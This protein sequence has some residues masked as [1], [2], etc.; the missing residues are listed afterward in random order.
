VLDACSRK[1]KSWNL[2]NTFYDN[3]WSRVILSCKQML[4]GRTLDKPTH[5]A[6]LYSNKLLLI[7]NK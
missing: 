3:P 1:Y 6:K 7:M 4:D 5:R 2:M